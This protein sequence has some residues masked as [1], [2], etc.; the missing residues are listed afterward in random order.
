[1][2]L[3]QEKKEAVIEAATKLA[4]IKLSRGE[5]TETVSADLT[6][7]LEGRVSERYA[8]KCLP[9]EFKQKVRSDNAS[10]ERA[11]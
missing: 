11:P 8:R 4:K 5:S 1:M 3:K 10:K 7:G 2:K 9:K 6:K